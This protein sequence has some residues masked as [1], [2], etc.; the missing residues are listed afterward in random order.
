[1]TLASQPSLR[2]NK[3]KELYVLDTNRHLEFLN[4]CR[5]SPE[6]STCSLA[7]IISCLQVSASDL[8]GIVGMEDLLG[9]GDLKTGVQTIPRVH[10]QP[11]RA[12]FHI[13]R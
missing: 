5:A 12:A 2:L 6:R 7:G 9:L 11:H 10:E 8:E 4:G 3:R 1:M 13:L